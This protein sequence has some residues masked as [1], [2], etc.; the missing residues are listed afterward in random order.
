MGYGHKLYRPQSQCGWA[1]WWCCRSLPSIQGQPHVVWPCFGS[2][3]CPD[4]DVGAAVSLFDAFSQPKQTVWNET[5]CLYKC[6]SRVS[7]SWPLLLTYGSTEMWYQPRP[8]HRPGS[9]KS[10]QINP[11]WSS[12]RAGRGLQLCGPTD[13]LSWLTLEQSS[14]PGWSPECNDP[15]AEAGI[16]AG[17]GEKAGAASSSDL[18][19]SARWHH[20]PWWAHG[21]SSKRVL[22]VVCMDSVAVD[23][24]RSVCVTCGLKWATSL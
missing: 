7:I 4:V 2:D 14:P 12:W 13:S 22:T 20:L 16:R 19:D 24:T 9:I 15:P 10:L 18:L 17:R 8:S 1:Q 3:S 21:D 5:R 23:A 6:S 11:F